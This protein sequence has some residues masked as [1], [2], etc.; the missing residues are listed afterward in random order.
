MKE[1]EKQ[2]H[3]AILSILKILE[4]SLINKIGKRLDTNE[5]FDLIKDL[6]N[7]LN[8][9]QNN[10]KETGIVCI[11]KVIPLMNFIMRFEKDDDKKVYYY[12]FLK[13]I[14]KYSARISF[15]HYMI[16][17]EWELPEKEKFLAPR[18][19]VIDGY[20]HYLEEITLNPNFVKL[21]FNAPSGFGKTYPEKISEAWSFGIDA[22]GTILSLCSNDNVVKGGSQLV[23]QEIKSEWFG[24][25]FPK[26][27]WNKEDKGYFTKDTDEEWKLRD[28]RL[29]ASYYAS[30]T[31]SNVVGERASKRIHID[32]LYPD[33]KEAMRKETNEYLSNKSQTVWEKRFL[34]HLIPK[35]VITGTL[36]ASGD[37]IDLQIKQLMKEHKF[38]KHSKYK[39]CY[40]SEDKTCAIIQIPALDYENDKSTC[41][42]LWTTEQLHR[43][44][45]RMDRYLWE[46]NFQQKPTNP[47]SLTF[48]YDKLRTYTTIP[49][50]DY[51]GAYSVIDATR[52]SGKDFFAM[53]IFRKVK[54][55]TMDDYYLKDALFTRTATKD[56]Y[57]AIVDKIIEHH[58]IKLVIESNVT[59]EL[60]NNISKILESKGHSFC[61][62]NEKYN[63][64]SKSARI[65][66]E[67]GIIKRQLIFP[68]QEMY[69]SN[70]DLGKFMENLTGYNESGANTNDDAPDSCA[71]FSSEIIEE[72]SVVQVAEPLYGIRE[73]L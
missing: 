7:L 22:T 32:D 73:Y 34:T 41:P 52:K 38:L 43:E 58:I 36:W 6:D 62:I 28:C 37:Y 1:E 61:E 16:Y 48:S 69:G 40:I 18:R 42:K 54:N 19:P 24:E 51:K 50:T 59:S 4:D 8:A 26:L 12:D 10:I 35:V 53:P 11:E 25:V 46:T 29:L 68:K 14:H 17:R 2:Y 60:K 27:K 30:T 56:M 64:E 31:N 72:N 63:T 33:Y 3:T 57:G 44:R 9:F 5:I 71:L 55:D 39:Y 21:I 67:K 47:D 45:A 49:E 65:E 20:I 13:T 70:T 23:K 66:N 15:L